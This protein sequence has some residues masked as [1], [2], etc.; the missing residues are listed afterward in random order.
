MVWGQS[1][2]WIF[3]CALCCCMQLDI[4]SFHIIQTIF[5]QKKKMIL[6]TVFLVLEKDSVCAPRQHGLTG[7]IYFFLI[8]VISFLI[9][10]WNV[11][12]VLPCTSEV[13]INLSCFLKIVVKHV[14]LQSFIY[15]LS[16][17]FGL[18]R[19]ILTL[20]AKSWTTTNCPKT[21]WSLLGK[22]TPLCYTGCIPYLSVIVT[23]GWA[24]AAAV[25]PVV[26]TWT[27]DGTSA[28][29][30]QY[31]NMHYEMSI[32]YMYCVPLRG[33]HLDVG[34]RSGALWNQL[35]ASFTV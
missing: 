23:L 16:P 9:W 10:S 25:A 20:D 29:E 27:W 4:Y 28:N 33:Y 30:E 35:S 1:C 31:L 32:M 7:F 6:L 5:R 12:S 8:I 13:C 15:T 22:K 17:W 26:G 3:K 19:L 18:R 21:V 11:A 2:L 34:L 24:V 14:E